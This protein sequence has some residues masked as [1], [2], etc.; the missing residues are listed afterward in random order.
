MVLMSAARGV[1]VNAKDKTRSLTHPRLTGSGQG[2]DRPAR[3]GGSFRRAC[4][5]MMSLL[6][7]IHRA[8]AS[9]VLGTV[10]RSP[11]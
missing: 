1:L 6:N 2:R 9:I 3:E 10:D 11:D 4:A 5:S 7:P 8:N